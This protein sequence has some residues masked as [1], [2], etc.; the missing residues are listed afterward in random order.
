MPKKYNFLFSKPNERREELNLVSLKRRQT[1]HHQRICDEDI[2]LDRENI[3]E[4]SAEFIEAL[5]TPH[6][7]ARLHQIF[8]EVDWRRHLNGYRLKD[9]E[10]GTKSVV[11]TPLLD[12]IAR[13]PL[14]AG[15]VF[16]KMMTVDTKMDDSM[17]KPCSFDLFDISIIN[18]AK[19]VTL[20][21]SY[22]DNIPAM[23]DWIRQLDNEQ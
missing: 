15:K 11:S 12:L 5:D 8:D 9:N 19:S 17:Y 6:N 22:F 18:Q 13:Y 14:F 2:R 23:K 4:Y 16:Y 20:D 3:V 10:D 1:I 7:E 21:Y